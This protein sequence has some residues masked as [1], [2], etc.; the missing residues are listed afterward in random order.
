M[1][2]SPIELGA[3]IV[4]HSLT[5]FINGA[6]D[7]V[8]GVVCADE[9]FITAMLDVNNGAGMLLGPVMDPYQSCLVY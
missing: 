5:K 9:E 3:D 2:I 1:V 4:I 7:A 6:S 8:G